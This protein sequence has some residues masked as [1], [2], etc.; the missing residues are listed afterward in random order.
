MSLNSPRKKGIHSK[1]NYINIKS[2]PDPK[3][4][5]NWNRI[6]SA[7]KSEAKR[8]EDSLVEKIGQDE[9]PVWQNSKFDEKLWEMIFDLQKETTIN[10]L[11]AQ[12]ETMM[13]RQKPGLINNTFSYTGL[14]AF[15]KS[16]TTSKI[17]AAEVAKGLIELCN[18]I[19]CKD[20]YLRSRMRIDQ[21]GYKK[22]LQNRKNTM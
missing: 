2:L 16:S 20:V 19:W 15:F 17:Y 14:V 11:I 4:Y 5:L 22:I 18:C 1:H 10:F 7:I 13:K 12:S 6:R 3:S 8:R 9:V 21:C